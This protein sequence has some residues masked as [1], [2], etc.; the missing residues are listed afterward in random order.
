VI[1]EEIESLTSTDTLEHRDINYNKHQQLDLFLPTR[2]NDQPVA[3]ALLM[4]G[5]GWSSG[6]RQNMEGMARWLAHHGVLVANISYSLAPEHKWPTQMI[7]AAQA[8][9]WLKK[10]AEHLNI[11]SQKIVAI[12][13]SAGGHLAA[14]LGQ[15]N[16]TDVYSGEDSSVAALISI[17]GPW[18][19]MI[20]QT[21][22][23]NNAVKTLLRRDN[24]KNRAEASPL[25]RIRRS[26]APALLIYGELDDQVPFDQA[27]K[28]LSSYHDLADAEC[29]LVSFPELGHEWPEDDERMFAPIK[30]FLQ[31]QSMM[32]D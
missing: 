22:Q 9:W 15:M 25:F 11:D 2:K 31:R 1:I 24:E 6:Q 19:L 7:D 10:N 26:S 28:V 23:Q 12:G 5:G 4:H 17:W 27:E 32:A 8:V 18:N 3:A 13:V 16:F 30:A 14:M 29:T 20:T 21:E